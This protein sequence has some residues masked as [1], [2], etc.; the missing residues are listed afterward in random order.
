MNAERWNQVQTLFKEIVE[1]DHD[2][3]TTRLEK[4]LETD[5]DLYREIE[6]LLAADADRTSILDGFALDSIDI[7][8]LFFT[9][10]T[11]IGSF[12]IVKQIG[13]GGMGNVYL[14]KRFEGGFEQT[15]ALKLIK[16]GMDS[17][18]IL[19]RFE[20]ERQILAR[21]QHPNIS[22]LLDGGITE[23]GRPWFAMEYVQGEPIDK[24]C[25]RKNLNIEQKLNLFLTVLSAVQYAHRNLIVHRDLKPYNI[26]VH[27]EGDSIEVKLLDFGIARLLTEDG[28][29][30]SLT[31]E[32]IRPMTRSYASP[33][34]LKEETVTT[35]SDIYSLGVILYE[36]LSGRRPFE[37]G[38]LTSR[39]FEDLICT[40]EPQRPSH[41]MGNTNKNDAGRADNG[42]IRRRKKQLNGDL[43]MICLKALRLE[44][45][46]RYET[47]DQFAEDIKRHLTERP[48]LAR[49]ESKRYLAQ[50]FVKRHTI[51]VVAT[52]LVL[53][54]LIAGIVAFAWQYRIAAVE[55]DR[56]QREADTATEIAGFLQGLFEVA[57]PA[58]SRGDTLTA[59]Q[60][61]ERGAKQIE[62]ELAEQPKVL[63]R[64]LDVLGNVYLSLWMP[65]EAQS[66]FEKALDV[67]QGSLHMDV[68]NP[69]IATSLHNIGRAS[70]AKGAFA[71]ADSVLTQSLAIRQSVL[72]KKHP[73]IANGLAALA[74][75]QNQQ[76]KYDSAEANYFEALSILELSPDVKDVGLQI[77][78]IKNN[79]GNLFEE[80]GEFERSETYLRQAFEYNRSHYQ[81]DHPAVESN[82][83]NLARVL[84][85]LAKYE[86]AKELFL[87]SLQMSK[88]LH[89]ERHPKTALS[90][91]NYSAF[92][93][94][95]EEYVEAEEYQ[96][97]AL[98]IFLEKLG[99]DHPY[100]PMCYN[101]LANLR[102]DRGDYETAAEYH[103]KALERF[104]DIYGNDHDAVANSLSNMGS[105]RLDQERYAEAETLF[106]EAL[107]IDSKAFGEA[108]PYVAMDYQAVGITLF[109]QGQY[110][111]A[112]EYL[113]QSVALN[114][115]V[116]G[117]THPNTAIARGEFGRILLKTGRR[118]EAEKVLREVLALHKKD[119]PE[120]S[121]R[122]AEIRS[123]LGECLIRSGRLEEA[124][125]HLKDGY[126]VLL[127]SQGQNH[128]FTRR[129][130]ERVVMLYEALG[131]PDAADRYR[132]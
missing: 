34:Q 16:Y 79:L 7:S 22:R 62:Q 54:S 81:S 6:S 21:L 10:G 69:E 116:L 45:E 52:L 31:Q 114:V 47:A 64:M 11:R 8:S 71:R 104:R 58:I 120:T 95:R 112:E 32:G 93:K 98:D 55:R 23:D 78:G 19:R 80:V 46:R 17:E 89:G 70:I 85:R 126:E 103:K 66:M 36:L 18:Q 125:S 82:M 99:E 124:K 57:D 33:E 4:V 59:R 73:D 5:P 94:E 105:V 15:V 87:A 2:S 132:F 29:H 41:T 119:Q 37:Q 97:Q 75:L 117:E 38:E 108:H 49:S 20:S 56:A 128:R 26:F 83:N 9:E 40:T 86:E 43:D 61:L 100:I 67:R 118:A 111:E 131:D 121:W 68:M 30:S 53:L 91:N 129:A 106:R 24:Y 101:N 107:R 48:I 39:E 27:H 51:G 35:A 90:M 74:H 13:S 42:Q 92:L 28:E 14:A 109:E 25:K 96:L 72:E 50:K 60:L 65:D 76:G 77:A 123:L 44:P 115:A 127:K 12:Q 122:T 102:N 3:R 84:V 63:A 110:P 130:R 113:R 1:L 88:R